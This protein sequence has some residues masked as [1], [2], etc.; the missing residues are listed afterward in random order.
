MV[1]LYKTAL[2]VKNFHVCCTAML[3]VKLNCFIPMHDATQKL[4]SKPKVIN[5]NVNEANIFQ[6]IFF[7]FVMCIYVLWVFIFVTYICGKVVMFHLLLDISQ[8]HVV[9]NIYIYIKSVMLKYY[10]VMFYKRYFAEINCQCCVKYQI[11]Q[12]SG[13]SAK[14]LNW[15]VMHLSI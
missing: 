13:V 10:E 1:N 8:S 7:T 11:V 2:L 3:Y 14:I 6:P 15:K 4:I 9:C 5:E 12:Q